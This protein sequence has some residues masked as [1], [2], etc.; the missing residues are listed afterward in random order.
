MIK[1]L[2]LKNFKCFECLDLPLQSVNIF[3]GMN[4][5][6]KSSV[7]QSLLLLYQSLKGGTKDA[8]FNLNGGLV[9]LGLAQDVFYDKAK[10]NTLEISLQTSEKKAYS[11]KSTYEQDTSFLPF[12]TSIP[13]DSVFSDDNFIYLSAYRIKP[14]EYYGV[15]DEKNILNKMFSTTGE[16]A[17]QYLDSNGAKDIENEAVVLTDEKGKSLL[18]QTRLWLDKIS[19]GASPIIQVIP[20]L[21]LTSL[22]FEFIEGKYKSNSYKSI[23]VGFGITYVLPVIVALLSAKSGDIVVIENPEAHIHPSGQRML[24]ELI[25]KAGAGGVQV[26]VETH[27]DHIIN[28]IRIAVK[29]HTIAKENVELA[30]FSKDRGHDFKHVYKQIKIYDDGKLSDWPA[31]FFDEWENALLDL[32]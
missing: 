15:T 20:E 22:G 23:N 17:L 18:N 24:G 7:I 16:F 13:S 11:Y 26:F 6:G 9:T 1:E 25:A 5:M 14:Q 3:T 12:I 28:G 32:L 4:G 27:S 30:F 19:P 10:D 2:H 21:R 31:G 29:N 8:G